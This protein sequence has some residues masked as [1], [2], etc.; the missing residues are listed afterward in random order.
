[1][2][3]LMNLSV[4]IVGTLDRMSLYTASMGLVD[5][6]GRKKSKAWQQQSSSIANTI[7]TFSTTR[8]A[9]RAAQPPIDTWSSC[10]A[11]VEIL[12]TEAGWHSPLFSDT[13][14]AAVTCAIM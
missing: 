14:A 10:P 9:L 4:S 13:N 1:M 6:R 7:S 5:L 2:S 3:G 8:S 11:E 12:S